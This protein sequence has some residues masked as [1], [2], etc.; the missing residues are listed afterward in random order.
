MRTMRNVIGRKRDEIFLMNL[1]RMF[2]TFCLLLNNI[3]KS[4][5]ILVLD[6]LLRFMTD[7]LSWQLKAV[8]RF[9]LA[10]V[11]KQ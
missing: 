7:N 1:V 6:V 10:K 11:V 9:G 2:L 3:I 4:M 5:Y 8:R